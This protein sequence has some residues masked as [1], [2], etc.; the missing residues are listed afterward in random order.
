MQ[1][2]DNVLFL[3]L[4]IAGF[5]LFFKSLKEIYRNIK[6]GREIKALLMSLNQTVASF[7]M[8]SESTNKLISSNQK[9]I[10]EVVSNANETMKSAK[11]A[12]DK[13]GNVS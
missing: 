4:L 11:I 13:Y 2:I 9:G 3:L 6:L 10:E 1:Y 12:V 7:K 8:T 5:G